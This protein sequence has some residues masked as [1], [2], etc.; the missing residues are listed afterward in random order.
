MRKNHLG[1]RSP[2]AG[3]LA[4]F[5]REKRACGHKYQTAVHYLH[6]LDRMWLAPVGGVPALSREWCDSFIRLRPGESPIGPARRTSIWRELARHARRR[7][8]DAYL[9]GP[10]VAP[11]HHRPYVPF[12]YT[13]AQLGALFAAAD[14]AT[15][16]YRCPR[17]PWIMGLMLRLL[18]GAG[19]RLGEAL[20]LT[21]GDY[22]PAD[23]VLTVR[24]GKNQK[25]R[26]IPLALTLGEWLQGYCRRFPGDASTPI[27]LSPRHHRPILHGCV[28]KTFLTLLPKAGLPPRVHS[29][30]P[31]IHD[32]RHTFAVHRLENWYLAGEDLTAKLPILSVYMGHSSLQN[33]YYYLRITASFFPEITRR[34]E[35]Y[36]GDVIPK[37][38]R[39]ET[40]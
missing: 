13:R 9:S 14:Q 28:E 16:N 11:I 25:D 36:A 30:G 22:D 37:E 31:R 19:L 2:L 23:N 26:Y 33:T 5:V 34:F 24:Q 21:M 20:A 27:F 15:A 12:I 39:H 38:V 32:L 18:Y 3:V 35:A 6:R 40:H 4:E 8:M 1:F 17:R 7:G 10:D 29:S